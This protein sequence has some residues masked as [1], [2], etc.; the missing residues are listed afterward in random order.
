MV[1]WTLARGGAEKQ[2]A[3]SAAELARA[4]HAVTVFHCQPDNDYADLLAAAEVPVECV[5]VGGWMRRLV[6]APLRGPLSE[7]FD[8]IHAFDLAC[9]TDV[10]HAVSSDQQQKIIAG[11]RAGQPLSTLRDVLIRRALRRHS[12]GGWIVNAE[13]LRGVV[14]DRYA[15]AREAV[16]VVPNA[17]YLRPFADLPDRAGTRRRFDVPPDTPV[18]SMVANL[19]PMKNHEMLFRV[20]SRLVARGRDVR[21]LLAGDG[22][23]WAEIDRLR[24]EYKLEA[25]VRMLGRIDEVPA[26]LAASEVAILT[27]HA[28]TEGVP[29]CLLEAAAAGC[30][31]VATR[32]GAEHVISHGETGL[33]VEPNDDAA[34]ADGIAKLLD[35]P[36]LARQLADAAREHVSRAFAAEYLAERLLA[37]YRL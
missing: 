36:V 2:C 1:N 31:I 33:L 29:N 32:C 30:P 3:I 25:T 5:D 28:G 11:C 27:S 19:R 15:A 18:V 22:P 12:P 7:G 10:L 9:L 21:I 37:A 34:M 6:V 4:G 26:L 24:R 17:I 35:E 23:R 13:A 8:V 14:V 20:V 16:T